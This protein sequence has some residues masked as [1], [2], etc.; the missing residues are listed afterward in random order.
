MHS[1]GTKPLPE[2]GRPH[3]VDED[4][5]YETTLGPPFQFPLPGW[6]PTR[7]VVVGGGG[8]RSPRTSTRVRFVVWTMRIMT[9]PHAV[10][11][12]T[13]PGACT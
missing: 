10:Q 3:D 2:V 7:Q 13:M 6:N 8:M 12:R 5:R 9:V 1:F 11:R 4:A